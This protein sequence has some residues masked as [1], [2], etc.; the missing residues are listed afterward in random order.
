V[1][2]RES[3]TVFDA[4][5]LNK[6]PARSRPVWIDAT[7]GFTTGFFKEA[8]SGIAKPVASLSAGNARLFCIEM[9]ISHSSFRLKERGEFDRVYAAANRPSA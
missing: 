5:V 9:M 4:A 8:V 2:E 3:L 7:G 1:P 6:R